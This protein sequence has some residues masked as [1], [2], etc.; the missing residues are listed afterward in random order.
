[1]APHELLI[2]TK[3]NIQLH[4]DGVSQAQMQGWGAFQGSPTPTAP[5]AFQEDAGSS[6]LGML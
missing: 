6:E 5:A 1:M 2:G 4:R 3:M